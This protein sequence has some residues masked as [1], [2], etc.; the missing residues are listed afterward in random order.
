MKILL[1]ENI[2]YR[3]I[4]KVR[5]LYPEIVGVIELKLVSISDR[6]I[7][8]YAKQNNY[9]IFTKDEDFNELSLFNGYPPK[10]IWLRESYLNNQEIADL[11][12]EKYEII[13]AFILDTE[14]GCLELYRG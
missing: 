2:S 12:I 4:K 1:D 13:E 6:T 11:L 7:W 8:T 10:I 14:L 9:T 5:H 3:V